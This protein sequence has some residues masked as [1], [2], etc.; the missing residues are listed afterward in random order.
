M[1][2]QDWPWY[3]LWIAVLVIVWW[4]SLGYTEDFRSKYTDTNGVNCCGTLDCVSGEVTLLTEPGGKTVDLMVSFIDLGNGD[5]RWR[6]VI[7]EGVPSGSVHR[8][9]DSQGYWCHRRAIGGWVSPYVAP[10]SGKRCGAPNYLIHKDC[11][12]CAFVSWGS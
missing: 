4:V 12:R 1:K 5:I 8:S 3:A 7:L 10:P 11:L 6:N 9:E 2:S